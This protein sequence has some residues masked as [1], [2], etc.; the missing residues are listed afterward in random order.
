MRCQIFLLA[1]I[2]MCSAQ[3]TTVI[4][5]KLTQVTETTKGPKNDSN[6]VATERNIDYSYEYFEDFKREIYTKKQALLGEVSEYS[7][8]MINN[9]TNI[10]AQSQKTSK[11]MRYVYNLFE[12]IK[13]KLPVL[14]NNAS[15]ETLSRLEEIK[16]VFDK[17]NKDYRKTLFGQEYRLKFSQLKVKEIFGTFIGTS[18]RA[19]IFKG[20]KIL[21]N[22]LEKDLIE[23]CEFEKTQEW[24]L[25]YRASDDGFSAS[26]FHS[27]C[28]QYSDTLTIVKTTDNRIFGGWTE[29]GF[30]GSAD[31][32]GYKYDPNAYVFS[33]VDKKNKPLIREVNTVLPGYDN[34]PVF[35]SGRITVLSI[36]LKSDSRSY[37]NTDGPQDFFITYDLEVW[38][39][40]NQN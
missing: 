29:K 16:P 5:K 21:N 26:S 33:L 9:I 10:Q 11:D 18:D 15:D 30:G 3:N 17:I 34:G 36:S 7:D 2:G 31:F 6:I 13:Q 28:D 1:F 27:E 20:S 8:Q 39:K 23:L 24:Q 19:Q 22:T 4:L 38:H 32:G 35:K 14:I 37:I 25:I 12:R 40:I